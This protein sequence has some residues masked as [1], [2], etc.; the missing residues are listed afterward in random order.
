[1][2]VTKSRV[3]IGRLFRSVLEFLEHHTEIDVREHI[4][5]EIV[6]TF[7]VLSDEYVFRLR[8]ALKEADLVEGAIWTDPSEL[9]QSP[10]RLDCDDCGNP[11]LVINHASSTGYRCTMCGNEYSDYLP[12]TCD[13]C[14]ASCTR[15]ELVH[16]E[17][18]NG[19]SEGRCY[20]C[21]GRY[22]LEKD[23]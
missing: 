12:A 15:N 21:S 19:E 16:W 17:N 22:R 3:T 5:D 8:D 4:P 11:T 18:E 23:D 14:G 1:M 7:R 13:I 6:E 20:Y 10:S 2:D 9:D